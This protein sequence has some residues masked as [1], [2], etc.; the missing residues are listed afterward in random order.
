MRAA[1]VVRIPGSTVASIAI[2]VVLALTLAGCDDEPTVVRD[3]IPPAA[4]QAVYSVTGD[5][6]VTLYW[7]RN[8]EPDLAGYRV[9]RGP[10]YEGPFNLLQTV[11]PTATSFVDNAV[12]NG[13]TYYYALAAYDVAGNESELS[14][15]NT[16]DTPRPAGAGVVL[17]S[18]AFEPGQASGFDFSAARP[19]QSTDRSADVYYWVDSQGTTRL[20]IGLTVDNVPTDVQDAGYVS[21]LD[22]L[23]WSPSEGWSPTGTVELIVGHGYYVWTRDNHYAKFRVTGLTNNQVQFDW[24][25]QIQ[26]GNQELIKIP[27]PI[28][29]LSASA[30]EIGPAG[31]TTDWAARL[32]RR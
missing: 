19:V 25:Y 6:Q 14:A 7:V 5:R 15:E 29:V 3:V 22:A 18:V 17:A 32:P 8:T 10:A 21:S 27:H 2:G 9:Y 24:A 31:G 1:P 13:T 4:P 28:R 11:G 26:V 30:G 16:K 20:M 23:D 12:T